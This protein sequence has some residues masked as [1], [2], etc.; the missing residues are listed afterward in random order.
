MNKIVDGDQVQEPI[1]PAR[2]IEIDDFEIVE[3]IGKGTYGDVFLAQ[4]RQTRFLC[5]IKALSKKKIKELQL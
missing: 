3:K 1:T 5:V 4:D 2:Q